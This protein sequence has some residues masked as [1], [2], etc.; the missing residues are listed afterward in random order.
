[1]TSEDA[2]SAWPRFL[3]NLD[4]PSIDGF[5]TWLVARAAHDVGLVV[6]LSG[7]GGDELLAG[8]RTFHVTPRVRRARSAAVLLPQ[9]AR[10]FLAR[11][12]RGAGQHN[13]ARAL[14]SG[15]GLANAYHA[16]RGL[17]GRDELM[18]IGLI[19]KAKTPTLD[20]RNPIDAVT[21]MELTTYL[22]DQLLIDADSVSM[23]HSIELRVPLLDDEMVRASLEIP[24]S[25]R[26]EGKNLLAEAAGLPAQREKRTFS[27][28]MQ[29]WVGTSLR[30]FVKDGVLDNDLAA[31][32]LLPERFRRQV[33][34]EFTAGKA[35]W[36]RAYAI[37]VLR[38]WPS[39]S[40]VS[41]DS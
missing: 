34:A 20:E 26:R 1:M 13:V 35:H 37:A 40:G 11:K 18:S 33:W 38:L 24:A 41:A 21:L 27:L 32:D 12:L 4:S 16:V 15:T 19:P 17:F 36:S 9:S 6:A 3:S 5:N 30:T 31:S 7:L 28:P 14:T 25:L 8:Y 23:A 2:A 29:N 10:E 39:A 22:R